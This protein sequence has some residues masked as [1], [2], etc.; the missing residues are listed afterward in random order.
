MKA[1]PPFVQ[2]RFDDCYGWW[3]DGTDLDWVD[4]LNGY[5]RRSTRRV[6]A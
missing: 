2:A 3:R 1:L 6:G 4:V 5:R